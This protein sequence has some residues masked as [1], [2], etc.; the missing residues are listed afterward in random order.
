MAPLGVQTGQ[1]FGINL[2]ASDAGASPKEFAA[3]YSSNRGRTSANQ[4]RPAA[5]QVVQLQG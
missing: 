5:W 3:M 2:N 1:V 4:V